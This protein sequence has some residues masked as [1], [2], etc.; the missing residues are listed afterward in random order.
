MLNVNPT[1]RRPADIDILVSKTSEAD[2]EQVLNT[3]AS[4]LF[5]IA[6]NVDPTASTSSIPA[7]DGTEITPTDDQRC[8]DV[9]HEDEGER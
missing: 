6:R 9:I 4:V 8:A 3:L 5:E 1:A 2:V 7:P